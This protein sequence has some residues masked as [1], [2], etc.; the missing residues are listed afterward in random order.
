MSNIAEGFE[1]GGTKE[2]LQFLAVAKGSAGELQ[3]H[4]YVALDEGYVSEDEF[5]KIMAIAASSKRL[6]AGFMNYLRRSQVK[7]LKYKKADP[8][9]KPQTTNHKP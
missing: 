7:G 2:F 3:S 1:R 8:S 9:H 6:I 4:F 5:A